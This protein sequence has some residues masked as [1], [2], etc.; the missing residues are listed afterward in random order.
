MMK[1]QPKPPGRL[2]TLLSGVPRPAKIALATIGVLFLLVIL[3]VV[4]LGGKTTNSDQLVGIMARAQEIARVSNLVNQ[5]S[6]NTDALGLATTA[7]SA[8]TSQEQQLKA[9]LTAQKIKVDPKL[10]LSK[11]DKTTDTQLATASQ[12]NN[13]EQTYYDYLK[14]N[15]G[16]YQ[17]ALSSAS[18]A[19]GPNAKAILRAAVQSVQTLLSAPQLK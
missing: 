1:D 3:Y 8:L 11:L 10:L 19:A 16:T 2:G 12:N 6:K 4:F 17:T 13:Y 14:N 15:L 5:Q 9:Y 7:S 18:T